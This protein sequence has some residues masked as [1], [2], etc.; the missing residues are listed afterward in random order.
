MPT[1]SVA[2]AAAGISDN[3]INKSHKVVYIS[4][5]WGHLVA[6]SQNLELN[7]RR[8]RTKQGL[9]LIHCIPTC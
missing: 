2:M 7:Q 9:F 8:S 1:N 6:Q 4:D 5:I 3:P